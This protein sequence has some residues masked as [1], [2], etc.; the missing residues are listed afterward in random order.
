[1][2]SSQISSL[3]P[4]WHGRDLLDKMVAIKKIP[5]EAEDITTEHNS[6]LFTEL[7]EA[8]LSPKKDAA[9][10]VLKFCVYLLTRVPNLPHV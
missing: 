3:I 10:E 2:T 5:V 7:S 8:G 6:D 9:D 4:N 1:M